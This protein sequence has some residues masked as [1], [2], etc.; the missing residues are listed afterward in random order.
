MHYEIDIF[1]DLREKFVF[2]TFMTDVEVQNL[3]TVIKSVS[4]GTS[5]HHVEI[6]EHHV[7]VVREDDSTSPRRDLVAS[8]KPLHE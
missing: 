6:L 5:I 7:L 3:L 1:Q 2:L 8:T 4:E